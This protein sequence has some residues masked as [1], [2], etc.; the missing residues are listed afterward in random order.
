MQ[1]IQQVHFKLMKCICGDE[2][3]FNIKNK[4]ITSGKTKIKLTDALDNK[5]GEIYSL[6]ELPLQS[7]ITELHIASSINELK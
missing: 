2:N 1:N 6:M 3:I 7:H 4:D 5:L